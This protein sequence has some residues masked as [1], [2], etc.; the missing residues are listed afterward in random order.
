MNILIAIL[1]FSFLLGTQPSCN[2]RSL[3]GLARDSELIAVVGVI[4][5]DKEPFYVNDFLPPI[6]RVKYK[7]IEILKGK[8]TDRELEVLH[9]V[10]SGT[11]STEKGQDHLSHSLFAVNNRLILFLAPDYGLVQDKQ[12]RKKSIYLVYEPNCGAVV[13]KDDVVKMVKTTISESTK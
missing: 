5:V 1:S 11:S 8:Y 9:Y 2:Q 12:G 6:Q 13:A 10:I 4:E 3:K 7:P